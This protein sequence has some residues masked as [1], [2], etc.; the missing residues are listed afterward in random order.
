MFVSITSKTVPVYGKFSVIGTNKISLSKD[1]YNSQVLETIFSFIERFGNINSQLQQSSSTTTVNYEFTPETL[2][3]MTQLKI[4]YQNAIR[5]SE[6]YDMLE[7]NANQNL[8]HL[9]FL[10][11]SHMTRLQLLKWFNSTIPMDIKT[12]VSESVINNER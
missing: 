6:I 5:E 10:K 2:S 9:M 11:R 8:T 1:Y 3:I 7:T 12:N 4:E